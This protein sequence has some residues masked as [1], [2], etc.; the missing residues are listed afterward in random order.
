MRITRALGTR[1]VVVAFLAA[2]VLL[3][4][5]VSDAAQGANGQWELEDVLSG[6]VPFA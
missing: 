5:P 4:Q 3:L 2:A 6:P 1:I